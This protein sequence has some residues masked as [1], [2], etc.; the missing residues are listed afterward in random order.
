V[1]TAATPTGRL[2][3]NA[4]L[5]GALA[6]VTVSLGCGSW[7]ASPRNGSKPSGLS[8]PSPTA[9]TASSGSSKGTA[10]TTSPPVYL[11]VGSTHLTVG[12]T[13]TVSG[14]SCAP[15]HIASAS[16]QQDPNG[17]PQVTYDFGEPLGQTI[18]TAGGQWKVQT[19]VPSLI[20]GK[21]TLGAQCEDP[22][23]GTS[24]FTYSSIVVNVA[25]PYQ[26]RVEPSTHASAGSTLTISSRGGGCDL[27]SHPEVYLW[28]A[29]QPNALTGIGEVN[30]P[31]GDAAQWQV[32]LT[33][34][35]TTSPGPYQVVARC[36]YSRSF[37]ITY[38]PVPLTV[39]TS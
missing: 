22:N 17:G 30:G 28:S 6:A 24:D 1:N 4:T 26:L 39:T 9:T 19:T 37:R 31:T 15:G 32:N 38:Q 14:G 35:T 2:G 7:S 34:P 11:T 21:A 20:I 16:L 36:A 18:A 13:I 5:I 33:V 23:S 12:G 10:P 29:A 3:R 27:V 8:S 25:T